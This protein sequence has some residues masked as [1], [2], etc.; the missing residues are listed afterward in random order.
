M[1]M[2]LYIELYRAVALPL[3]ILR[4]NVSSWGYQMKHMAFCWTTQVLTLWHI[5]LELELVL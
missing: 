3:H 1:T 5:E 2:D 4:L